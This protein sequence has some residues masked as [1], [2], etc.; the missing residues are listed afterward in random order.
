MFPI[1]LY[2]NIFRPLNCAIVN[3]LLKIVIL[4]ET[5]NNHLI[6][7]ELYLDDE[8]TYLYFRLAVAMVDR[9]VG[10]HVD[11]RI[12]YCVCCCT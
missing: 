5:Q 10:T 6:V 9:T 11:L 2:T 1:F 7:S 12:C 8:Q 4:H 3:G